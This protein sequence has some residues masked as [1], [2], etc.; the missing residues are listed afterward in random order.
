MNGK[1]LH[2]RRVRATTSRL[3]PSP[4]GKGC[5]IGLQESLS[6]TAYANVQ[7]V[8]PNRLPTASTIIGYKNHQTEFAMAPLGSNGCSRP[9]ASDDGTVPVS[10]ISYAQ[11]AKWARCFRHRQGRIEAR[12]D[13][14]VL[15]PERQGNLCPIE[16]MARV[17]SESRRG[18]WKFTRMTAGAS[19]Q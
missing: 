13:N 15:C 1:R 17:L 7:W 6:L 3:M 5:H 8:T 18:S 10:P 14:G 2:S 19:E 9:I 11:P 12:N 4:L 16:R